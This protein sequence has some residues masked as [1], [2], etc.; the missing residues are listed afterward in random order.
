MGFDRN[1]TT[2]AVNYVF[3]PGTTSTQTYNFRFNH[4]SSINR[5]FYINRGRNS[6]NNQRQGDAISHITLMEIA[7]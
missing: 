5:T 4:D 3:T 6:D 7:V 2:V 1:P